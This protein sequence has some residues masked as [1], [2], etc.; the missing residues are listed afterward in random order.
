MA[1]FLVR[2]GF[3]ILALPSDG[4]Y[5]LGGKRVFGDHKTWRGLIAS[6]VAVRSCSREWK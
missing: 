5:M 1:P 6:I 3:E 2:G 4:G